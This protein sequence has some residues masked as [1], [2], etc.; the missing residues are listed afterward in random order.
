MADFTSRDPTDRQPEVRRMSNMD[1]EKPDILEFLDQPPE[2]DLADE[3]SAWVQFMVCPN[4][5]AAYPIFHSPSGSIHTLCD[6]C[7][8]SS[9]EDG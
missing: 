8:W 9:E 7:G 6:N 4:C 5:S 1:E 2:D 3:V